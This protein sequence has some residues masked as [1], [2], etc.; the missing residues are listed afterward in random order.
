[1]IVST[2]INVVPVV[3]MSGQPVGEGR[4]GPVAGLLK[5]MMEADILSLKM[6]A[7]F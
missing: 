6:S 2:T 5:D 7:A 4:P 3:V 1:M